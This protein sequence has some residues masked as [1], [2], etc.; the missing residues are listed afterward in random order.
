MFRTEALLIVHRELA[1]LDLTDL[2]LHEVYFG[3]RVVS[4]GKARSDGTTMTYMRQAGTGTVTPERAD[5]AKHLVRGRFTTDLSVV[6]ERMSKVVAANETLDIAGFAEEL[7][8]LFGTR[9]AAYLRG[10]YGAMGVRARP[11][12]NIRKFIRALLPK[13]FVSTIQRNRSREYVYAALQSA[14]VNADG[15]A[16]FRHEWTE[17]ETLCEGKAF[18]SFVQRHAPELLAVSQDDHLGA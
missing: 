8:E 10:Y 18:V 15:I 7:R 1:E 14:G 2:Q 16:T 6:S 3:M 9:L 5:W 12:D 4:L 13:K 17:I 11:T